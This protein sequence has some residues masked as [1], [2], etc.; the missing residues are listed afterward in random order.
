MASIVYFEAL[1][2]VC[3]VETRVFSD[4]RVL[5]VCVCVAICD[6]SHTHTY[7]RD[8]RLTNGEAQPLF[9]RLVFNRRELFMHELQL[10]CK[11][12]YLSPLA[13]FFPSTDRGN[14]TL[15]VI[16]DPG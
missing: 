11:S 12:D 8:A 1:P 9:T 13:C 14:R 5:C 6:H 15:V 16:C 2:M 7:T 4:T 3:V 10:Y